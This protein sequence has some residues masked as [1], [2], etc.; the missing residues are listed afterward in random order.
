MSFNA[1]NVDQ[2]VFFLVLDNSIEAHKTPE[3]CLESQK[4]K[5]GRIYSAPNIKSLCEAVG[6]KLPFKKAKV[7]AGKNCDTYTAGNDIEFPPQQKIYS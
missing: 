3:T 5:G 1:H 7:K 2:M 4:A 6:S